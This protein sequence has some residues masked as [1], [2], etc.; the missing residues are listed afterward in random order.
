MTGMDRF[1]EFDVASGRLRAESGVT[2]RQILAVTVPHGWFLP[3]TPG[4]QFVTL[5]GAVANDVHGKNHHRAGTFG[6]HVLAVGLLRSD[7]VSNIATIS[8]HAEPELY[9]ATIGGLGLTGIIVWVE[10]QLS[11]VSS[12]YLDVETLFYM[13]LNEFW[14]IASESAE[15]F[16]HTVAWFDCCESGEKLGRGIFSRANWRQDR[17]FTKVD[18]R[19]RLSIPVDVPNF[20]LN[21]T[22]VSTF[23][24]LYF[25]RNKTMAG[26]KRQHYSSFLFP[27]DAVSNWNRLY[28]NLGFYQYQCVVP[29][30]ASRIAV[31]ALLEEV[32]RSRQASFLTVIKTFGE[33]SS[34]GLLS[35][36][37]PGVTLA[38]DFPN[39]GRK[40]LTVMSRLDAIVREAGGALYPAKDGRMPKDMFQHS[41]PKWAEFKKFKDPAMSSDLWRRV[42]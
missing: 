8:P 22:S 2:L 36:P 28:G 40:T 15:K 21:S 6:C 9:A 37:R 10:I 5:G 17:Q 18:R 7:N 26:V 12:A 3:T 38:L 14:A 42:E 24:A 11:R 25:L 31:T 39:R 41:F 19:V 34:P 30:D 29:F 27:L 33:R 13:N 4:T 20:I 1:I 16:E 35:F 23:N 32:V